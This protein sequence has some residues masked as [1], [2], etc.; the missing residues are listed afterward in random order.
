MVKQRQRR[1]VPSIEAYWTAEQNFL[2]HARRAEATR[3]ALQILNVKD[4][5]AVP[6]EKRQDFWNLVSEVSV[7]LAEKEW[8]PASISENEAITHAE[9]ALKAFDAALKLDAGEGLCHLGRASLLEQFSTFSKDKNLDTIPE[10]L[11]GITPAVIRIAYRDAWTAGLADA[12]KLE[13]KP[14]PGLRSIVSYEAGQAFIRLCAEE[15]ALS[16]IENERL[17]SVQDSIAKLDKLRC[18]A[19]TSIVFSMRQDAQLHRLILLDAAVSFD[20]DG[21]GAVE[22]WPW[23]KS[24]T[25]FL[26]WDPGRIGQ[27][28]SGRQL[29]GSYTF[30]IPWNHGYEP[31]AMLDTNADGELSGVE[32]EG[33]RAWFDRDSNGIS[34]SS[35]VVDLSA[36][37][38]EAVGVQMEP[39]ADG[40]VCRLGLRL[41]GGTTLAT[42]D[43]IAKPQ[44]SGEE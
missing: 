42:W 26:V 38:I 7:D 35:E 40:P 30:Q 12:L 37:G 16:D 8:K 17:K 21:D 13:K 44:A 28:A 29:F 36:L 31:L 3:R 41:N 19:I 39:S 1:S 14:V 32:I 43:W 25:G 10:L 33:I 22:A 23:V 27:V 24:D 9:K 20:L 6:Q 4:V 11:S 2:H 34:S 5:S 15:S 18:G